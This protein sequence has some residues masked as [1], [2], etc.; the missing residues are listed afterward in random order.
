MSFERPAPD[1]EKLRGYWEAWERGEETPGR[2]L[3]NLKTA[4]LPELLQQLADLLARHGALETSEV[5]LPSDPRRAAA[6]VELRES[7][8]AGVNRRVALAHAAD[9]RVHKTAADMIVPFSGFAEM[10]TVSPS[11]IWTC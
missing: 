10:M 9:P 5:V 4:G 6:F 2:V 8:P 7:V 3:A 11:S 1:L